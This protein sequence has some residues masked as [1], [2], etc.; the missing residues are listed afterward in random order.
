MKRKGSQSIDSFEAKREVLERNL[1][2]LFNRCRKEAYLYGDYTAYNR[3]KKCY[4]FDMFRAS[5]NLSRS[6]YAKTQRARQRI[7]QYLL[8]G[9][10]YFCT[11]TFKDDILLKTNEET[12]RR[13]VSRA[14]KA[15]GKVY[16]A[17]IDY[18]TTTQREHYHACVIPKDDGIASWKSHLKTYQNAPDLREW[19]KNLGF[20]DIQKVGSTE[21]DLIRIPKYIAKLSAHAVKKSTLQ[22]GKTPRLIYSRNALE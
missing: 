4:G 12:R 13:Y 10:A 22:G 18:G 8:S 14:L 17:N 6:K 2:P 7:G 5:L 15:I 16:V 9:N 21:K 19:E 1:M 3:Y 20:V 11:L